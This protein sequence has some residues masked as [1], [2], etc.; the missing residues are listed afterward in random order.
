MAANL[1][2]HHQELVDKF[3]AENVN[4]DRNVRTQFCDN[5]MEITVE[6]SGGAQEHQPNRLGRFTRDGSLWGTW[7]LSGQ[8][9][10]NSTLPLTHCPTQ[11]STTSS[12]LSPKQWEYEYQR[13]WFVDPT[14]TFRCTRFRE[15]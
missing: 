3:G 8:L 11:L 2:K 6:S 12:G 7:F 10:T 4:F 1:P 15:D 9:I 13:Q 5:C 14:L